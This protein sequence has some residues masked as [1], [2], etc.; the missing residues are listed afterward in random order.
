[1]DFDETTKNSSNN[2]FT[3]ESENDEND[4]EEVENPIDRV[5][6]SLDNPVSPSMDEHR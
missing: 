6:S 2:P 4:L 5:D 3:D 1:M